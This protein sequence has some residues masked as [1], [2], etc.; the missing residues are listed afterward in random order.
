MFKS[1][2]LYQEIFYNNYHIV[3]YNSY[4]ILIIFWYTQLF[5]A[6][7]SLS[8]LDKFPSKNMWFTILSSG[9]QRLSSQIFMI[10]SSKAMNRIEA[11]FKMSFKMWLGWEI[12]C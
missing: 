3:I 8:I 7:Y 9:K 10:L 1:V 4:K 6:A 2:N 5:V 12:R 11:Y